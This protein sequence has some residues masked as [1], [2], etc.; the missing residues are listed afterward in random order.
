MPVVLT[1]V[2]AAG[3]LPSDFSERHASRVEAHLPTPGAPSD[4]V[5][6]KGGRALG[7]PDGRTVA[8]GRGSFL[9]VRFFRAVPN[10]PGPDLRIYELGPDGAQA[11]IAVSRG[12]ARFVELTTVLEGPVSEIDFDDAGLDRVSHVRIRGLDDAGTEP[13]FDLDALEAL[14]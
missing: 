2:S 9:V 4:A 12:G 11:K 3:C 5:F 10:G 6:A 1:L 14:Q 8:I 7:P 13:G